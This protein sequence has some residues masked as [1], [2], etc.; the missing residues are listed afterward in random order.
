MD[1]GIKRDLSL[2]YDEA[3]DRLPKA[4]GNEGFGVLTEID[5]GAVLKKKL[6]LDFRKYKIFGACNP[7]LAY[8]ALEH[9]LSI[10]VLLPCN[11]VVYEND[12]G[13][14]TVVAVDPMQTIAS[15][16]GPH[17]EEIAGEVSSRLQRVLESL[18]CT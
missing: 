18:E 2:S 4:L 5:V 12:G 1:I 13:A 7:K 14:A 6:D 11:V 15:A 3:L 8:R 17:V 10:G 16:S 9:S